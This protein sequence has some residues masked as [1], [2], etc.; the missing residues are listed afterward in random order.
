M[1][2]YCGSDFPEAEEGSKGGDGS[3]FLEAEVLPMVLRSHGEDDIWTN[4]SWK[5]V[6]THFTGHHTPVFPVSKFPSC[7]SETPSNFGHRARQF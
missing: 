7:Q 4:N 1:P 2:D 5:T 6:P 3:D